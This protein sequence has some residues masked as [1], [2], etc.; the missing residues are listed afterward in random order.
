MAVAAGGMI[1]SVLR[2]L[3]NISLN[4]VTGPFGIP[5]ATLVVN[6]VGCFAI[7]IL[8]AAAKKYE[9]LDT[10]GELFVRVGILGGLTTFSSFGL[11]VFKLWQSDRPG[12]AI[13]LIGLNL[14]LGLGAVLLG[15]GLFR[16]IAAT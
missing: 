13:V 8:A 9:W 12:L 16:A 4:R 2:H 14:S 15:D 6:V 10:S 11:E 1:G 7:G 5:T 3:V